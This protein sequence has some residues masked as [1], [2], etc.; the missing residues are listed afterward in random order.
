MKATI[1]CLQVGCAC[2][3]PFTT[4]LTHTQE[5]DRAEKLFPQLE[6][7][8]Y[9]WVYAAGPRKKH[10]C[11]IAYRKD[12]YQCVRQKVVA[13]DEQEVR[14]EGDEQ[15]RRGSS[16]R[17]K[18]IGS[19]VALRRVR[20]DD[21]MVIATT[22]LFWHPAYVGV[23]IHKLRFVSDVTHIQLHIR[24]GEV[25]LPCCRLNSQLT[26]SDKLGFYCEKRPGSV[27]KEQRLNSAGPASSQVVSPSWF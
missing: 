25:G 2:S 9:A 19:L 13:Y 14:L 1:C 16:F 17:T 22:H 12:A 4:C 7:A 11:L 26:A 18:N 6:D 8:G 3:S 20:E 15:A 23:R 24:K 27:Q 21:G 10:G 5:V